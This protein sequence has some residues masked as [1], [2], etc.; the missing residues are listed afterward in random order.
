MKTSFM[1]LRGVSLSQNYKLV[2]ALAPITPNT[3]K[4]FYFVSYYT[5][6]LLFLCILILG[7]SL[8]TSRTNMSVFSAIPTHFNS[9]Q[10]YLSLAYL[11]A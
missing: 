1:A 11:Y 4:E 3:L 8:V 6:L 10:I 7:D 5:I 2:I 9:R